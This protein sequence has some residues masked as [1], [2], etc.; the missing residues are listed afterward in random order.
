MCSPSIKQLCIYGCI[1][2]S[3]CLAIDQT[4]S[5]TLPVMRSQLIRNSYNW[6]LNKSWIIDPIP[7]LS[8]CL[9]LSGF[10]V[11]QSAHLSLRL[12][13]AICI[14]SYKTLN[15]K[16]SQ[17]RVW[18]QMQKDSIAQWSP[19]KR[20]WTACMLSDLHHVTCNANIPLIMMYMVNILLLTL[21]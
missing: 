3:V 2:L 12:N 21:I 13:M 7:V 19:S 6:D 8:S 16:L 20:S 17:L 5:S 18:L 9:L 11:G 14:N 15:V 1:S 4:K 10:A